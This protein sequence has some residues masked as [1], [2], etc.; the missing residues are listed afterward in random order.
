M[1]PISTRRHFL[2]LAATASAVG[3]PLIGRAQ[4][5]PLRMVVAWPAGG[6]TDSVARLLAERM[7]PILKRQ[8]NIDNRPGAGGQIGATHFK[9]LPPDGEVVMLGSI[10]E[11]MLSA[12]TFKK[13]PYQPL[14]DLQPVSLIVESPSI[15]AVPAN[16]PNTMTEFFAWAKAHPKEVT[17]GCPGL[18]TPTYFLG[19]M[20]GAKLGFDANMIPFA[21][22]APLAI[23]LAGGQVVA[24]LQTFGPDF[25]GMHNSGRIKI[26]AFTGDQRSALPQFSHLPTFAEAGQPTIPSV[27]FGLFLPAGAKPETV[28]TWHQALS[29]VLAKED[30][31]ARLTEFGLITRTSTPQAFADLMRRDTAI[32]T[33]IVKRTGFELIA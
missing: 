26:T 29:E 25:I 12:V 21:G 33:D 13:L 10:N 31:R 30:V 28:Q 9:N 7:A 24:A 15:L 17:I 8:I 5:A 32:W 16:G 23:G 14:Q 6:I 18:G 4:N 2:R 22:G 3:F 27:W 19:L 11:T 20:L 1:K